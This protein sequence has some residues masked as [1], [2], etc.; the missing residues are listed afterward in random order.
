MV[1]KSEL[2]FA[3]WEDINL[4][5]KEWLI[6]AHIMKTKKEHMVYLSDKAIEILKKLKYLAGNS[7]WVFPGRNSRDKPTH[8]TALNY[9]LSCKDLDLG[10]QDFTIH[11]LR[12]TASTILHNHHGHLTDAIEMA[13]AHEIAGKVRRT[14]N[15]AE[16]KEERI[17]LL[18]W[19]ANYVDKLFKEAN[20]V[21]NSLVTELASA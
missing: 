10:I 13:M 8:V 3:R 2:M 4:N 6:P 19:L 1:R 9:A 7:E 20:I 16:Y 15:R 12:R 11:D 17:M 5:K 21:D 14:Y 18:N